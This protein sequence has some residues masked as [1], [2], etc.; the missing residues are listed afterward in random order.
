M[1]PFHT[2]SAY[3]DECLKAIEESGDSPNDSSAVALVKLQTILERVHQCSWNSKTEPREINSSTML[4]VSAIQQELR[5][6]R[7]S[8]HLEQANNSKLY[9]KPLRKFLINR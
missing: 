6:L 8:L 1:D 7:E 9:E 5:Q 2:Y 3:T 4:I